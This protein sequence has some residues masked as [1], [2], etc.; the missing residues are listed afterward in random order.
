MAAQCL[1]DDRSAVA[2]DGVSERDAAKSGSVRA[3]TRDAPTKGGRSG[4]G[5]TLGQIV[6]AYKSI[7]TNSYIRGVKTGEWEPF[8]GRFWQR[9]YH[10]HI[11]RNEQSL[12]KIRQYVENNPA[13]WKQDKF[14]VYGRGR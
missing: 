12:A 11:I 10:E 14:F 1:D 13:S 5:A 8:D 3:T 9:N 2:E 7:T 4:R 6:G